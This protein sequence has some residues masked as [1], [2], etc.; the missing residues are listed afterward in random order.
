MLSKEQKRI[1][2]ADLFRHLDGIVSIPIAYAL[3]SKGILE[4]LS[5]VKETTLDET[6]LH[7]PKI[8]KGYLNVAFRVLASQAWLA[9]QVDNEKGTIDVA[10]NE[11]SLT[12][13]SLFPKYK[14]LIHLLQVS[15][16]YHRRRFEKEPFELLFQI[17]KKFVNKYDIA[18]AKNE[19]EH[20][21]QEQILK[22]IE[23]MIIG[24]SVVALGMSGMFHKYFMESFFKA[25]EFHKDGASFEKLLDFFVYLEWF[26]KKNETYRFTPKGLFY[27]KRATAY[28]VTV[29]YLPLFR[30]SQEL[31]FGN[32]SILRD[33][34]KGS[35]ELHVDR[36]MNVWGSGGAH[37]SYF[38]KVD[39]IIIALF[40]KPIEEQ[41][42]GI[43]DM[44]CGNGAYL[45]H[46]YEV[47]EQRTA[48][49]QMLEE[50][51]LFLVGADYN[52]AALKVTRSNLISANIWAKVIWG[53]IGRPDLLAE[54]LKVNYNIALEDLLNVRTFLDHNRI[55]ETPKNRIANRKSKSTGAFAH[56]GQHLLN[57]EVEDN[58]LEHFQKWAPYV[59]KFGL[60]VI[61]LHTIA[62]D[63]TAANLGRTA[64]TAYDA[65][66]GFSDQYIVEV[67][68][69]KK[70]AE[71]A[72]LYPDP[73]HF[74]RF[75]DSELATVSINLLKG[76]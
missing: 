67:E 49:G 65:T 35:P 2:R 20:E 12:A 1:L 64:A 33:T 62:P 66:H 16:K 76:K 28:G 10:I 52:Q 18:E 50:H 42:K 31:L 46:L 36:E 25:E 37:G 71:E 56:R 41:P 34:P 68:V 15:E 11:R 13:F 55:W 38:K 40:N 72:G 39:E 51:P 32:P 5:R 59:K 48:R 45:Q 47:I 23:G 63:L 19:L 21:V 8:N 24:P 58:L 17:I 61:E 69:F 4:Y 75:P 29:S 3:H 60:L 70:L 44:G 27:A 6:C 73:K 7:F 57:N 30:K 9:Y 74:A 22:H 54:D 14:D 43:V 26:E 53:D